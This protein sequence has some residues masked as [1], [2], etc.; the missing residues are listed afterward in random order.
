MGV[1]QW[2]FSGVKRLIIYAFIALFVFLIIF[3]WAPL[4]T[5]SFIHKQNALADASPKIYMHA[6]Y[7][8]VDW[9]EMSPHLAVAVIAA[10]DQRFIK[11][12]GVDTIELRSAKRR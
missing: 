10:E 3:R 1:F 11:H 8:W 4:P 5:S 7:Q 6:A 12:W 9:D 2:F